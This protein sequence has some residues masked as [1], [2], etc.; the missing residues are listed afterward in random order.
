MR[1]TCR[2]GRSI[3]SPTYDDAESSPVDKV[4]HGRKL[5]KKSQYNYIVIGHASAFFT[6]HG[7]Q[8]QIKVVNGLK[9]IDDCSE[10]CE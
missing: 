10:T 2:F 8:P 9:I 7:K 1:C 5:N 3:V 6:S 4:K